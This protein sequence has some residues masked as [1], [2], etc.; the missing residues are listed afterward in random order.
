M[1]TFQI[2]RFGDPVLRQRAA[3]VAG[4]DDSVRK[5]IRDLTDTMPTTGLG[6]AAPQIG[7]TRRVFVWKNEDNTGALANPRLLESSG[8]VE[9][10]E[11]CLSLPGLS[12]PVRRAQWVRVEG[13][14]ESD[15]RVVLEATDLTARIFQHEIDHLDG[16]L[17]ID[18]LPRDLQR[19]AR[20]MLREQ[21]LSG[22]APTTSSGG[23]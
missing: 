18:H 17:F 19:E 1:T 9:S 22:I 2:R 3:E 15:Q 7:I 16:V 23:L 12:F 6:L 20:R 21:M 13:L 14:N 5:L 8:E 10:D 11:G 4:V